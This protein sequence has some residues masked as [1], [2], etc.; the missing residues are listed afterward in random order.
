MFSDPAQI[1]GKWN[2]RIYT[3][4]KELGR[5][6]NGIV[7]LVEH[8]GQTLALKVGQDLFS[9]TSEVNVLKHFQKA[10]GRVL[11]PSLYDVDDWHSPDGVRPFYVMNVIK[12]VPLIRFV[13]E[14]GEDWLPVL[15]LQLLG[16]LEQLHQ[17]GWVFGDL[18][19]EH[20]LVTGKP[21][22]LA[23]FDAGGVTRMGW[24]IKE[25]TEL[26][27]RGCW[28]MGDRKAESSYDLF[29]VAL[30][31]M[32]IVRGKPL[33]AGND[34]ARTLKQA[35][36]ETQGLFPYRHVLWR[37]LSGRY[38]SAQKMR[39][40]WLLA[41]QARQETGQKKGRPAGGAISAQR[42]QAPRKKRSLL[43]KLGKVISFLFISSF[44]IFLFALYLF[45]QAL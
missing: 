8:R 15:V 3:V 30:I 6:A 45:Y 22:R 31:V 39:E 27:D 37:A 41:W 24:A 33:T 44:L 7:Y 28:G 4:H 35:L 2:G 17:E 38:R 32:H 12:G 19:P 42:H 5:G 34:P 40:D 1:T 11:G 16:F 43:W 18:K 9:L 25:Y 36:E 29:S 23:W 26:Y 13:K 21:P 10:Q 14:R 20:L